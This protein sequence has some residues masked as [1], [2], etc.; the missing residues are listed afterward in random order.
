M[1]KDVKTGSDKETGSD[2]VPADDANAKKDTGKSSS[3]K[4][5]L[6]TKDPLSTKDLSSTKDLLSTKDKRAA[7]KEKQNKAASHKTSST[8]GKSSFVSWIA[9][10]AVLLATGV[11]GSAYWIWLQS[12]EKIVALES[13]LTQLRQHADSQVQQVSAESRGLEA[14]LNTALADSAQQQKRIRDEIRNLTDSTTAISDRMGRTSTLWIIAEA[15][16]LLIVASHRLSLE[17]D[18][19]TAIAALKAADQRL[20]QVGDPG[21]L[22]VRREI[23]KEINV[24]RSVEMPDITGMAFELASLAST[25]EQLPL[26]VKQRQEQ[27]EHSFSA[28]E[29]ATSQ[30]EDMSG[31]MDAVW[32]DIKSLVVIRKNDK[33]VDA[34]LAP[35]QR[36]FLYQNLILKLETGRLAL[37][38]GEE[39]NLKASLDV[40][41]KW[42]NGY[43]DHET[44]AYKHFESTIARIKNTNLTPQLPDIS[45]SLRALQK[46][47]DSKGVSHSGRA[48]SNKMKTPV[49]Q[50]KVTAS[51]PTAPKVVPQTDTQTQKKQQADQGSAETAG[52]ESE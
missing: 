23:A 8:T 26:V 12:E 45:N 50:K 33:P 1:A 11:G 20:K 28:T 37:L 38:R 31:V 43:F 25:A 52:D 10:V 15:E 27:F 30:A 14:K 19:G 48:S 35:D 24:L 47:K 41:E 39:K 46:Y 9:I 18:V 21:V 36:H 3:D 44:T 51:K 6:S 29:E 49:K 17:Q 4:G 42:I 13:A 40:A 22:N 2:V 7:K 34:L 32:K 16:Y 5:S